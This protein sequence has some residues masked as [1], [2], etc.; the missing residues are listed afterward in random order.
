MLYI[1]T[2]VWLIHTPSP[3]QN[4]LFSCFFMF[5]QLLDAKLRP[6]WAFSELFSKIS[7]HKN[8]SLALTL[9]FESQCCPCTKLL[10]FV[11]SVCSFAH[12]H[13]NFGGVF[14]IQSMLPLIQVNRSEHFINETQVMEQCI[15]SFGIKEQLL[16]MLQNVKDVNKRAHP[17]WSCV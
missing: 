7:W 17:P 1:L 13:L 6:K 16:V 2:S 9:M 5:L 14:Q 3:G 4:L 8:A 11:F 10:H 15:F 12:L